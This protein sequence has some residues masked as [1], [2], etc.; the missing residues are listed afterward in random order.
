MLK[1]ILPL[2]VLLAMVPALSSAQTDRIDQR[3]PGTQRLDNRTNTGRRGTS[4]PDPYVG[5]SVSPFARSPAVPLRS[6][7]L[8][9]SAN[10]YAGPPCGDLAPSDR[11]NCNTTR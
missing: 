4:G 2:A 6:Q 11:S 3:A 5:G 1:P 9:E 8:P 7:P 10:P